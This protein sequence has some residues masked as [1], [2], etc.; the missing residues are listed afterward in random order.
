M[1]RDLCSCDDTLEPQIGMGRFFS[2]KNLDRYR[3][4]ASDTVGAAERDR[5]LKTLAGEMRTFRRECHLLTLREQRI[6][7]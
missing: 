1:N 5:V 4:L 2:P 3:K 6:P 7:D